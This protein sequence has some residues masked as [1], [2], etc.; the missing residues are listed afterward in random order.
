LA[1]EYGAVKQLRNPDFLAIWLVE[2]KVA[3]QIPY[4]HG[5]RKVGVSNGRESIGVVIV[6]VTRAVSRNKQ[7]NA[8]VSHANRPG[9]CNRAKQRGVVIGIDLVQTVA[10]YNKRDGSVG[11]KRP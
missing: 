8:V 4:S 7:L 9:A 1:I 2:N 5:T 6:D 3:V 10:R 11:R